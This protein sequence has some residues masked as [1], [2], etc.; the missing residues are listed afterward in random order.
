M[1]IRHAKHHFLAGIL[2]FLVLLVLPAC[3]DP[4]PVDR[5]GDDIDDA[6][7]KLAQKVDD[8]CEPGKDRDC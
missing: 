7:E 2:V 5:A 3:T 8:T 6:I 1:A 4:D